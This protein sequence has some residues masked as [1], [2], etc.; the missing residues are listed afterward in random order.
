MAAMIAV[1]TLRLA[2]DDWRA[3]DATQPLMH[4]L[5]QNFALLAN[6]FP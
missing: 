5:N 4:Y 3:N 2:M 6:Q 1:G